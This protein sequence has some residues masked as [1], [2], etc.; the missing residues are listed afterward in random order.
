MFA[1]MAA[2][3]FADEDDQL[4]DKNGGALLRDISKA[5]VNQPD[6]AEFIN[7]NPVELEVEIAGLKSKIK[8]TEMEFG[9]TVLKA[10]ANAAEPQVELA[11]PFG[12]AEG[13]NCLKGATEIPTYFDTTTE[14]AVGTTG[15]NKV[16]T[17]TIADSGVGTNIVATVHNLKFSQNIPGIGFCTGN[18]D[19]KQGVVVNEAFVN[20]E[21]TPNLNI[22]FTNQAIPI[23]GT[24]CPSTGTL[25]ANFFLETPSTT[26]DSA[27]FK[28]GA[29]VVGPT[30][31]VDKG[32]VVG[33]LKAGKAAVT[34]TGVVGV[35]KGYRVAGEL[36][37]AKVTIKCSE[38]V[39]TAP[40]L[41][42]GEPGKDT[43]TALE[44]RGNCEVE[45]KA[46]CT[47]KEPIKTEA[48]RSELFFKKGTKAEIVDVWESTA[49]KIASIEIKNT[50]GPNCPVKGTFNLVG[51]VGAEVSPA[52]KLAP[53][54]KLVFPTP[55]VA[56]VETAGGGKVKLALELGGKAATLSGE[57]SLEPNEAGFTELG[58]FEM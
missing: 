57:S 51:T 13:D 24:N 18:V 12:V 26:T 47:V 56:E 6:A 36:A 15:P 25:N 37:G 46:E 23:T 35:G 32:G 21:A 49:A 44:L 38:Q 52:G 55:A 54:G 31:H 22:T 33:I 34:V 14:G 41:V 5:P 1:F 20:E 40:E 10:Q 48:L 7:H 17:I 50:G 11:L 8:C 58:V 19:G 2:S 30:W 53:K 3:A 42:G 9:T 45:G 16:A 39:A 4:R 29:A 28:N 27:F 43:I